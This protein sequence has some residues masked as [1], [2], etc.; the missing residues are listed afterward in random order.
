MPHELAHA[1]RLAASCRRRTR[2]DFREQTPVR[3]VD[4]AEPIA[5]VGPVIVAATV[6]TFHAAIQRIVVIHAGALDDAVDAQVPGNAEA[7]VKL[8]QMCA[9]GEGFGNTIGLGSYR[10]A[11]KCG[12]PELSMSVKVVLGRSGQIRNRLL[13]IDLLDGSFEDMEL[14]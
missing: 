11:E 10:L 3:F 9:D 4:D 8:A 7:M 13:A 6:P 1:F 14:R 12:H 2:L 5:H